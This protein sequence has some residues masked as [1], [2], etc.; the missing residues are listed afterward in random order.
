MA[1]SI[2]A[3]VSHHKDRKIEPPSLPRHL[4]SSMNTPLD[5][6]SGIFRPEILDCIDPLGEC[7]CDTSFMELSV[8]SQVVTTT[9]HAADMCIEENDASAHHLR[10]RP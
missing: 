1:K 3:S 4:C 5:V 7:L 10:L 6:V 8:C 9:A 2:G